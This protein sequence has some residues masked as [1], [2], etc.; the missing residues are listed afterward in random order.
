MRIFLI[1]IICLMI[2]LNP[3]I[4]KSV[5][6]SPGEEDVSNA[7]KGGTTFREFKVLNGNEDGV[8]ASI[9]ITGEI[10]E[11]CDLNETFFRIPPRS[12][13]I[14]RVWITPSIDM[15]TRNYTGFV[16][17]VLENIENEEPPEKEGFFVGIK[18]GASAHFSIN[19]VGEESKSIAVKIAKLK[20]IE[21]PLPMELEYE[22]YNSGNIVLKPF[23][24]LEFRPISKTTNYAG[25]VIKT[26]EIELDETYPNE[27]SYG[28]E[29]LNMDDEVTPGNYS[30]TIKVFR[31]KE[32]YLAQ[33]EPVFNTEFRRD[34]PRSGFKTLLGNIKNLNITYTESGFPIKTNIDFENTGEKDMSAKLFLEIYEKGLVNKLV[35][36]EESERFEIKTGETKDFSMYYTPEYAGDYLIKTKVEYKTADYYEDAISRETDW[37]EKTLSLPGDKKRQEDMES[38]LYLVIFIVV[39]IVIFIGLYLR[40]KKK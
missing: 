9:K 30:I 11:I 17:T 26:Y 4:S 28:I 6:I 15:P 35:Y 1:L 33:N 8:N 22:T 21:H 24:Y 20:T 7:L 38:N 40:L 12:T 31:E 16:T 39:I 29:K 23:A 18:V 36:H 19:L 10:S 3:A 34:I 5:G 27:I 14:V 25:N 2:F 32:D 13:K 37:V